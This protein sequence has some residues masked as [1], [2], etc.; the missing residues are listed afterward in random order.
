MGLRNRRRRDREHAKHGGIKGVGEVSK[1]PLKGF[2]REARDQIDAELGDCQTIGHHI[3]DA[4]KGPAT[5]PGNP[6]ALG[7]ANV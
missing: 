5:Q 7:E 1:L 4:V 3:T 2:T 6:A